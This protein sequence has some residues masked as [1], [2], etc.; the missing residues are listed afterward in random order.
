MDKL[1]ILLVLGL[2]GF[3]LVKKGIIASLAT[4]LICGVLASIVKAP[5]K[6]SSVGS[7]T[8]D[9]VTTVLEFIKAIGGGLNG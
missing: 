9:I 7:L 4:L 3:A 8:L 5:G 2:V 6:L 1:I